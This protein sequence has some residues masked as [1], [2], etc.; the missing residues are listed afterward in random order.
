M[1]SSVTSKVVGISV[2]LLLA[3]T[4]LTLGISY[5]INAN[6]TGWDT[7]LATL[8]KTGVPTFAIIGFVVAV[9]YYAISSKHK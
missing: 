8:F 7:N 9:I 6:T 3:G 4:L 5:I 2:A 1:S